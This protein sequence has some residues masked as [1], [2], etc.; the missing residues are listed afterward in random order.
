MGDTWDD[1]I[2]KYVVFVSDWSATDMPE[3][4]P[5]NAPAIVFDP[6]S[7]TVVADGY[8]SSTKDHEHMQRCKHLCGNLEIEEDMIHLVPREKF[9]DNTLNKGK[10]IILIAKRLREKDINVVECRDDADTA[11]VKQAIQDATI[12]SVEVNYIHTLT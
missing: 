10:L 3:S 7:I 12:G 2:R 1:I 9:L 6:E 8:A 4:I 11:V 5:T